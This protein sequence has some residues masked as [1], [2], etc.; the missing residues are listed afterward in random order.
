[1][2]YLIYNEIDIALDPFPYCGGTSTLDLLWMGLPMVTLRG[3]AGMSAVGAS[4]L[5]HLGELTWIAQTLD[6]YVQ[7][8]L[9]LAEDASRLSSMRSSQRG[10]MQC[11]PLMNGPAFGAGFS[12]AI[13]QMVLT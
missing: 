1:M 2:Q 10:R 9:A 11:S 4:Y 7:I 12:D 5:T 13:T 3:E 6:D 8:S